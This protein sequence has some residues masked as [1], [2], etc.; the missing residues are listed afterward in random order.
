MYNNVFFVYTEPNSNT[1]IVNIKNKR[2]IDNDNEFLQMVQT[3]ATAFVV[4]T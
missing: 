2:F 4:V 1:H 3:L